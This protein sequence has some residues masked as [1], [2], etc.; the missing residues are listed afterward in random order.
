[1]E[2]GLQTL[3]AGTCVLGTDRTE[4]CGKRTLDNLFG[5]VPSGG[6]ESLLSLKFTR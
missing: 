4:D 2:L 1:M 3:N 6:L 5:E